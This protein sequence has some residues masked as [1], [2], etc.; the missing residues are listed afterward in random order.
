MIHFVVESE[1]SFLPEGSKFPL[2]RALFPQTWAADCF[3]E[4]AAQ[5]EV[6]L[7][8]E[9][10][11]LEVIFGPTSDE[12]S[13]ESAESAG[14]LAF[15]PGTK[16]ADARLVGERNCDS[17][18]GSRS[19]EG[20]GREMVSMGPPHSHIRS[21]LARRGRSGWVGVGLPSCLFLAVSCRLS[22]HSWKKISVY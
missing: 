14:N 21:P 1:S 9:S 12:N 18:F 19:L 7:V 13:E 5:V 17:S 15:L 16:S 11:H 10:G 4:P 22:C 6:E 2:L 3:E 8:S 20:G